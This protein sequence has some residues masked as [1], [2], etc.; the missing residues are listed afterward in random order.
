[1]LALAL[2]VAAPAAAQ[3]VPPGNSE[4]DQYLPT[5]GGPEGDQ[6]LDGGGSGGS[7]DQGSPGG[8]SGAGED[9]GEDEVLAPS[10][11]ADLE[12]LG[13]DGDATAYYAE[14]TADRQRGEQRSQ[15]TRSGDSPSG[16]GLGALGGVFVGNPGSGMGL[17]LPLVLALLATLA[18]AYVVRARRSEATGA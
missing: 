1:V 11:A 16:S 14:S 6:P 18:I 5:L 3:T 15:P 8:S 4:V 12:A 7:G 2:M 10:V 9:T 17:L 13:S